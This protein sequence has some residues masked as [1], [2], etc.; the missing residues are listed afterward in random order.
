MKARNAFNAGFSGKFPVAIGRLEELR[1]W[2]DRPKMAE[3]LPDDMPFLTFPLKPHEARCI[4]GHAERSCFGLGHMQLSDRM[5]M[6]MRFQ[7]NGTQLYWIA[8]MTDPAL[9]AALDMWRKY[10]CVPI[11]FK[12][13]EGDGW[14][15]MFAKMG[16]PNKTLRD[17][18]YRAAPRREPTA[19]DFH[20]MAGLVTGYVQR[21]ATTDIEYIPLQHVFASV[22]LT[23]QY[24]D[25]AG[26]EPPVKKPVMVLRADG[27]GAVVLG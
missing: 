3:G 12:V 21:Q 8:E 23:K 20:E 1:S 16:F 25:V 11:G 6:T 10:E 7:A 22:L 5:L 2:N 15:T 14:R 17:E 19:Q 26:E 27:M 24:E 9:W 18:M 13:D 4:P